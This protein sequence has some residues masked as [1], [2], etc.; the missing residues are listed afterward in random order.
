MT[1][2]QGW[3][4]RWRGRQADISTSEA[5]SNC[6]QNQLAAFCRREARLHWEQFLTVDLQGQVPLHEVRIGPRDR[7]P[8]SHVARA[9]N[10]GRWL[11]PGL[12]P[13]RRKSFIHTASIL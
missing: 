5:T 9:L 8:R 11:Q 1:H 12:S 13:V 4:E 7:S 2:T 10:P 6:P 3:M